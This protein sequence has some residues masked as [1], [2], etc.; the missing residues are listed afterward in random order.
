[1]LCH[2]GY[3][4]SVDIFFSH[5]V[6]KILRN[7]RNSATYQKKIIPFIVGQFSCLYIMNGQGR[8]A[9]GEKDW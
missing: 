7:P 9:G 8:N 2:E 5:N 3:F 1:M 6:K 4:L